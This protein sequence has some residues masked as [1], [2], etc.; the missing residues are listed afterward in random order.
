MI[1]EL[2]IGNPEIVNIQSGILLLKT[3]TLSH[4]DN[5]V[6]ALMISTLQNANDFQGV[7]E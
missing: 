4:R 2:E 6:D 1:L 3:I 5:S 7:R